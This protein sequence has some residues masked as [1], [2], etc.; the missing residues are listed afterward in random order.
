MRS[1]FLL[2]IFL[3]IAG[4]INA[5]NKDISTMQVFRCFGDMAQFPGGD[6]SLR[7]F[8]AQNIRYPDFAVAKGIEGRCVVR[9]IINKDGHVSDAH[10]LRGIG[11]G[12]D[13]EAVR[14]VLAMPRWKTCKASAKVTYTLPITFRLENNRLSPGKAAKHFY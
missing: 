10:V 12:C 5:Q 9:F 4:K 8:L 7:R 11:G 14:V 1:L 3:F 13:E 6:D 2:L